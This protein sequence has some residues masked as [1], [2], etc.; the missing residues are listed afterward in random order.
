M[1]SFTFVRNML[2]IMTLSH[3]LVSSTLARVGPGPGA[4]NDPNADNGQ[5]LT[6]SSPSIVTT[7][8]IATTYSDISDSYCYDRTTNWTSSWGNEVYDSKG[9]LAYRATQV[10]N[11]T[12]LEGR[13]FAILDVHGKE[14]LRV[15][16]TRPSCGTPLKQRWHTSSDIIYKWDL[17]AGLPDRWHIQ[18]P[19]GYLKYD[20]YVYRRARFTNVGSITP[21]FHRPRVARISRYSAHTGWELD[22]IKSKKVG[23]VRTNDEIPIQYLLGLTFST[24]WVYD[25][26][27]L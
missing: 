5:P 20:D 10:V 14:L 21:G 24:L 12:R 13:V 2:I 8:P 9:N 19:R 11:H 4:V 22:K 7:P 3:Y 1:K 18:S 27:P 6:G 16:Q 25:K 17:R 23:C 15:F 26:C